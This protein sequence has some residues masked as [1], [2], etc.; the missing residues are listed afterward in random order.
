MMENGCMTSIFFE[1]EKT[2]AF[3][4]CP[5]FFSFG[6]L[7]VWWFGGLVV[8]WFGGLVVWW[9]GGLVVWWFGS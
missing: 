2:W 7:V 3:V 8:W 9:F 5:C 6:G 1:E 4:V